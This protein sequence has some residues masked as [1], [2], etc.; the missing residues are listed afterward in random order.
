MLNEFH[1]PR[2]INSIVAEP[3]TG[4]LRAIVYFK[5][6]LQIICDMF[7]SARTDEPTLDLASQ[8]VPSS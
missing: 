5:W 7:H 3:N 8:D 1:A 4:D 6:G 2:S